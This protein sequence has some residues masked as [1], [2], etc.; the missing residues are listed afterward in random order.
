[1]LRKL[2]PCLFVLTLFAA[3][4]SDKADDPKKVAGAF[5]EKL[6]EPG[7]NS[8]MEPRAE[9]ARAYLRSFITGYEASSGQTPS[10]SESR[11]F[12]SADAVIKGDHAS[13]PINYIKDGKMVLSF[14]LELKKENGKWNILLIKPVWE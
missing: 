2:I 6:A 10:D 1:M 7:F 9:G 3:A 8:G 13:I 14:M 4:C 12:K 5:I 11:S